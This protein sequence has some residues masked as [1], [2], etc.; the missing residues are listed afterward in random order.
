MA[1]KRALCT[2]A[3]SL[4][5]ENLSL[6]DHNRIL[7]AKNRVLDRDV[8]SLDEENQS[9]KEKLQSLEGHNGALTANN[10]TLDKNNNR[11]EEE[12]RSLKAEVKFLKGKVRPLEDSNI[13]LDED[14]K[15]LREA[16]RTLEAKVTR[17]NAERRQ[18]DESY[19][20]IIKALQRERD[21]HLKARNASQ[22]NR[23]TLEN[24]LMFEHGCVQ[25]LQGKNDGLRAQV[26]QFS[27][28][29]DRVAYQLGEAERE[30]DDLRRRLRELEEP[31]SKPLQ[32]TK[33]PNG[34]SIQKKSGKRQFVRPKAGTVTHTN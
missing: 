33:L 34:V 28:D 10:K 1:E 19:Q 31:S 16:R 30:R 3:N 21:E 5:E 2:N 9:L 32:G 22:E 14:N 27:Q 24:N 13:S 8:D 6:K 26:W 25:D 18:R 17:L 11:L 23:N 7:A 20:D 12:K 29:R 4:G 15:S